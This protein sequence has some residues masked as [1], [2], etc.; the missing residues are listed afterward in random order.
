MKGIE[1]SLFVSPR[2]DSGRSESRGVP[3]YIIPSHGKTDW[4]L[5]LQFKQLLRSEHVD[6]IH[7]HE[8]VANVRGTMTGIPIVATVPGKTIF[9]E[10]FRRRL[11]YQWVS[12]R[13]T[14]GRIAQLEVI[15]P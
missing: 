4:R 7:A 2:G 10:R 15:H 3:M 12:R 1:G 14:R 8:F 9:S 13:A 11:A 5:A 6:P